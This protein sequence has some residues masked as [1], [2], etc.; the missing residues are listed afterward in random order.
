M[1]Y[2]LKKPLALAAGLLA[3]LPLP[4][5]AQADALASLLVELRTVGEAGAHSPAGKAVIDSI[6]QVTCA[7]VN[8][9]RDARYC[10]AAHAL[11]G[12]APP[13]FKLGP[14]GDLAGIRYEFVPPVHIPAPALRDIFSA[15]VKGLRT[16]SLSCG[17]FEYWSGSHFMATVSLEAPSLKYC[18]PGNVEDIEITRLTLTFHRKH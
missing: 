4:A 12:L 16:D 7:R 10:V 5:I 1:Q 14:A 3:V 9:S 13:E 11:K 8:G 18:Q 2:L 15:W 6:P 17:G